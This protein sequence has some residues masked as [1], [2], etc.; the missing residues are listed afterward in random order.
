MR[1]TL[2]GT[3]ATQFFQNIGSQYLGLI[4]VIA[5]T[6]LTL[7]PFVVFKYGHILRQRSKF[8]SSQLG[9]DEQKDKTGTQ[10]SSDEDGKTFTGSGG[11]C[12][13]GADTASLKSRL[14][15][16]AMGRIREIILGYHDV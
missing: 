7:V 11:S 5:G 14:Q 9:G 6:L 10:P 2:G 8:A 4:L 3:V 13:D 12:G 16:I 1:N 15:E